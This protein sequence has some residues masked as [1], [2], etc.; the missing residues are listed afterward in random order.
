MILNKL[1]FFLFFF[2]VVLSMPSLSND[3]YNQYVDN[4]VLNLDIVVGKNA[5]DLDYL[6]A[7]MIKDSFMSDGGIRSYV[8]NGAAYR[9]EKN[10]HRLNLGDSLTDITP[11]IKSNDF[12]VL[13][14][15]NL[16]LDDGYEYEFEQTIKFGS[17]NKLEYF[18]DNDYKNDTPDLG[19]VFK[20]NNQVFNH[21]L[22]FLDPVPSDVK[23][24]RLVDLEGGRFCRLGDCLE[25]TSYRRVAKPS[26]ALTLFGGLYEGQLYQGDN[27]T[28]NVN[29]KN[30]TLEAY[31]VNSLTGKVI[32]KLNGVPLTRMR[33]NNFIEVLPDL[34]IG[35]IELTSVHADDGMDE[36]LV[37]F[38]FGAMRMEIHSSGEMHLNGEEI[39]GLK[40]L[41]GSSV[42][43]SDPLKIDLDWLMLKWK[44]EED[45]Y[46]TT[47]NW[48]HMPGTAALQF[49]MS[50]FYE[51]KKEHVKFN[52]Q[53]DTLKLE[54]PLIDYDVNLSLLRDVNKDG[55]WDVVGDD[56]DKKLITKTKGSFV[57]DVNNDEWFVVSK[58]ED[59]VFA[60]SHIVE[61]SKLNKMG[62]SLRE[63]NGDEIESDL[64]QG[65]DFE[66][67]DIKLRLDSYNV[68]LGIV[69]FTTLSHNVVDHALITKEGLLINLP[70]QDSAGR[71]IAPGQNSTQPNS[72]KFNLYVEDINENIALGDKIISFN[73]EINNDNDPTISDF[74]TSIL[75]N[76]RFYEVDEQKYQGYVED[77][78]S[79][80]IMIDKTGDHKILD[81]WYPGE[82]T[83][84]VIYL[85]S[86]GSSLV[87]ENVSVDDT[88][89]R[90]VD[91]NTKKDHKVIVIGGP[92][93]NKLSSRLL[94]VTYGTNNE[95]LIPVNSSIV[96]V[97]GDSIVV[98]G[99]RAEDTLRAA[100]AIAQSRINEI[101][102]ATYLITGDEIINVI[103]IN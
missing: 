38:Y 73:A 11:N 40:G 27:K 81:L 29:G 67:G 84:A 47:K 75:S 22:S 25:I 12:S 90:I 41:A 70:Y 45:E 74:N 60:E 100:E 77:P 42:I 92:Y 65:D 80:K 2:L 28:Y 9:F 54:V 23:D 101:V 91:D 31:I 86:R 103:K 5:S 17:E 88:F 13:Q 26:D 87:R 10:D 8:I 4:R 55:S 30:Y 98:A 61:V 93:A 85:A 71:I 76:N 83:Y 57:Y 24:G 99:Y 56:L 82:E 16:K 97:V 51:G 32:F 6:S 69:K 14:N 63:W 3:L 53:T 72:V 50:G 78:V 46:L 33:Q 49:M 94:N 37:R 68:N 39:K 20:N 19:L 44:P 15:S 7:K 95:S 52:P 66:I 36:D 64:H 79:T 43:Q 62:V 35:V 102:N 1:I 59:G 58:I 96:K 18:S 34:Y 48:V 21:T 89:I